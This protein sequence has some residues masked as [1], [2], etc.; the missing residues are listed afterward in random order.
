MKSLTVL[1]FFCAFIAISAWDCSGEALTNPKTETRAQ[2]AL[3]SAQATRVVARLVFVDL[4]NC[5]ACTRKR[6]DESWKALQSVLKQVKGVP[7]ER[8]H[9]DTQE[10]LAQ[11]YLKS[12]P[13]MVPPALYFIDGSGGMIEMIQGVLTEDQIRAVLK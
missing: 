3:F 10:K 5:C 8:I 4:E 7:L 2:E 9:M 12:N 1:L 13:I 6:T 11:P